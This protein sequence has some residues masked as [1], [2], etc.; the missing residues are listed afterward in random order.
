MSLE[1]TCENLIRQVCSS[2]LDYQMN[3]TPY[4][5]Y[6]SI[7]KKFVKGYKPNLQENLNVPHETNDSEIVH[8]KNEYA[9]LYS[10]LQASVAN[11]NVLKAEIERLV[12]QLEN[13]K[14]LDDK[15]AQ[16]EDSKREDEVQN[17][18]LGKEL[19]EIK[20]KYDTKVQQI[21]VL[22]D[23]IDALKKENNSASVALKRSKKEK[24]EMDKKHEKKIKEFEKKSVDLLD[25]KDKKM[26]EERVIK[27]KLRKEIKKEKKMEIKVEAVETAEMFDDGFTKNDLNFNVPVSN[28]F[29][30]LNS[31]EKLGS[32]MSSAA[33]V[34]S[35]VDDSSQPL[36]ISSSTLAPIASMS[37]SSSPLAM[38]TPMNKSEARVMSKEAIELMKQISKALEENSKQLDANINLIQGNTDKL[39]DLAMNENIND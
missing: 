34:D 13:K 4:S 1:K 32:E 12:L 17:K 14:V 39:G 29:D 18:M 21:K 33:F 38:S 31:E 22:R 26:S 23:E 25:F 11:E 9:K 35:V 24:T 8:I 30:V 3:Q 2:K 5:I 19:G 20:I 16:L 27:L 7:R 36:P 10:Y 28:L 6:F 37:S 15:L